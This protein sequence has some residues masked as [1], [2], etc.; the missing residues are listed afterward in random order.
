VTL[1]TYLHSNVLYGKLW[2]IAPN[3]GGCEH[4]HNAA[5]TGSALLSRSSWRPGNA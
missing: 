3:R 1:R 2:G 4:A 5:I